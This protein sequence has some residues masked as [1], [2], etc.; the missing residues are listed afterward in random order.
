MHKTG[1]CLQM[2][3]LRG[4][5]LWQVRELALDLTRGQLL[6]RERAHTLRQRGC[7]LMNAMS[8]IYVCYDMQCSSN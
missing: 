4:D 8:E 7:N 2:L 3:G 1:A 5:L 6:A